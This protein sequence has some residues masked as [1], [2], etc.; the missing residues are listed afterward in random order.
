MNEYDNCPNCGSNLNDGDILEKLKRVYP[1]IPDEMVYKWALE[2]G[3]TPENKKQFKRY[4]G[5]YDV[6]DDMASSFQCPDCDF[7]WPK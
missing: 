5:C 6:Y 1:E 3:W 7:T 4:V 2:Y